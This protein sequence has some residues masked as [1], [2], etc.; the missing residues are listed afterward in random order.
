MGLFGFLFG[1]K[2][3]YS[4]KEA[5]IRAHKQIKE[6]IDDIKEEMNKTVDWVN[7]FNLRHEKH[8]D[9]FEKLNFRLERV[10]KELNSLKEVVSFFG[11]YPFKQ[12]FKQQQTGVFKQTGVEAVQTGVETGVQTGVFDDYFNNLTANE[13]AIVWVLLNTELKMSY[14]DIAVLLGKER[15]TIRGQIN[16]IRQK[17]EGLIEEIV[18]KNGK[19]RVFIPEDIK[20]LLL[21]DVKVNQKKSKGGKKESYS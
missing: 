9:H 11:Q 21:K 8:E 4:D 10:E 14:E 20:I 12:V 13:R 19:K 18:E 15:S 6:I 16:A 17:N 1:K 5:H 7:H 2:E 3:G